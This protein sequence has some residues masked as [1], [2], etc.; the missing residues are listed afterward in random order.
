M[1]SGTTGTAISVSIVV[2]CCVCALLP[3][4]FPVAFGQDEQSALRALSVAEPR[5]HEKMADIVLEFVSNLLSA[6]VYDLW[7]T[8]QSLGGGSGLEKQQQRSDCDCPCG[9][10]PRDS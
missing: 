3:L 7:K 5:A 1:S 10:R 9:P 4:P 2:W 6:F 8:S